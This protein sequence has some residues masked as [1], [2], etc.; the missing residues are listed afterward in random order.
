M[1]NN[2]IGQ[3]AELWLSNNYRLSLT[4]NAIEVI[5]QHDLDDDYHTITFDN[6]RETYEWYFKGDEE[7]NAHTH[8]LVS[9]TIELLGWE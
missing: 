5:L 7:I 3:I 2:N 8:K 6:A 9:K 1:F 4:P